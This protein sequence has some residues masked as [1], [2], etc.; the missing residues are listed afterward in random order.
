MIHRASVIVLELIAGLLLL[1]AISGGMLAWQFAKGPIRVDLLN[2]TI[3]AALTDTELGISTNVGSTEIAWSGWNRAFDLIARDVVIRD[4][5][6]EVA[7]TIDTIAIA[8]SGEALIRG[9]FRPKRIEVLEPNVTVRHEATGGWSMIPEDAAT[10]GAAR[11]FDLAA[12]LE[13]LAG[14]G[15][16]DELETDSRS[17]AS[18][19]SVTVRDADVTVVDE[20][21]DQTLRF[22]AVE[23]E[24]NRSVGGLAFRGTA[25]ALWQ[26][27]AVSDLSLAGRYEPPDEN[28]SIQ[29]QAS[30]LPP[31][32]LAAMDP[33]L[34]PLERLKATLAANADLKMRL[35]TDHIEGRVELSTTAGRFNLPEHLANPVPLGGGSITVNL[36]DGGHVIAV[37]AS[38]D[39]G[40]PLVAIRAQLGRGGT[41]WG[42]LVDG[43]VTDLQLNDLRT[44]WPPDFNPG[45]H[46]WITENLRDGKVDGVT[47]RL[48]GWMD[49]LDIES[50][51][52]YELTGKID[53]SGVTTHYYRQLPPV[54]N[55]NGS[56][57]F[58]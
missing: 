24:L 57:T 14:G 45:T 18:L 36:S 41:G 38:L 39:I 19:V 16:A 32:D 43:G 4:R 56:A 1:I 11:E 12:L 29:L 10:G 58:N 35:G 37:D 23:L 40:G 28:L 17:L 9:E 5:D 53:F 22:G 54:V 51:Q 42:L 3:G 6:Q 31:T 33:N 44:Y 7:A 30:G 20:V 52:V 49:G 8:L 25:R 26:S 15:T 46:A 48:Q 50:L 55:S 2:E 27:G 13:P 34:A 47:L 21:R